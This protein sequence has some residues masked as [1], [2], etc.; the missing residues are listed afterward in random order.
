MASAEEQ[1][2]NFNPELQ[3]VSRQRKL[4]D[5]L[6]A[7]GMQ[8]PQ[9]QMISGHYVAPSWAQSLN[10]MANILAGQAIGE[11]ADTKQQDLAMALRGRNAQ[12]IQTYAQLQQT[13]P[14]KAIQFGLNSQNP[15]LRNLVSK[16]F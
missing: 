4:A 14:A 5:L 7:S 9:G 10:P 1:A 16:D 12:D 6:M 2:L 13:D 8:Q 11:R 3:D 15:V